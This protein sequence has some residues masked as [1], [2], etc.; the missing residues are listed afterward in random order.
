M[1]NACLVEEANRPVEEDSHFIFDGC[2]PSCCF[3]VTVVLKRTYQKISF[4]QPP[5]PKKDT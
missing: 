5:P 1:V 4:F 3:S 2:A